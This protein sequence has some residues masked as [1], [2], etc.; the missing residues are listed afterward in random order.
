MFEASNQLEIKKNEI[1]NAISKK[2]SLRETTMSI[3]S[4]KSGS[5]GPIPEPKISMISLSQ[6]PDDEDKVR[7]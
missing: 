2:I 5:V 7:G 1:F 3:V 6:Y 4:I